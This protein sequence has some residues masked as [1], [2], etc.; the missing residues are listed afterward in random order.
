MPR[1][2]PPAGQSEIRRL[3]LRTELSQPQFA[4]LLGVSAEMY[5]RWDSG[6]RAVP[7]AWLDKARELAAAED[8]RRLWSLQELATE[9]GVHVQT[10][11]RRRPKR[12]IEGYLRNRVAFGNPIPKSTIQAG[13]AFFEHYYRRSYSRSAPKPRTPQRTLVPVDCARRIL[14][15]RRRLRLTQTQL[16]KQ[17]GA[18]GKAVVYQWE[19]AKRKPSRLFWE[20]IEGLRARRSPVNQDGSR[21]EIQCR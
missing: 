18:A 2:A 6:R 8:P 17:I 3:R 19:S 11:R 4:W 12:S 9:L 20:K 14:E 16:A 10:L 21:E 1:K 5:R 7:D 13:R 15:V